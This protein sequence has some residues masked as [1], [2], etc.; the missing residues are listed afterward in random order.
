M[1]RQHLT[2]QHPD[3]HRHLTPF[4]LGVRCF[5]MSQLFMGFH[6]IVGAGRRASQKRPGSGAGRQLLVRLKLT[7]YRSDIP[8][9][10][11]PRSS[12]PLKT[13]SCGMFLASLS[14]PPL[15]R[16][17]CNP[18][19]FVLRETLYCCLCIY[20]ISINNSTIFLARIEII[21]IFDTSVSKILTFGR[22]NI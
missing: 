22:K 13:P 19:E 5:C 11:P 17:V 7:R 6:C 12:L 1:F 2:R 14:A 16:F 9:A 21:L 18:A 3:N 15:T 20:V 4:G 10:F 8:S